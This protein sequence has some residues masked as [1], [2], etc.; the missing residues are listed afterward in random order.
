MVLCTVQTI[1]DEVGED[2]SREGLQ[3]TPNR[4]AEAMLY[5]TSGYQLK[6]ESER[7]RSFLIVRLSLTRARTALSLLLVRFSGHK[8]RR[9]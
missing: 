6:L 8:R 9:L 7:D 3:K 2:V 1:L 4:A 5:L